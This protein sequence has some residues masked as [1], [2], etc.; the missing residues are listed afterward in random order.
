MITAV[1]FDL[2]DTLYDEIDYVKSG[3]AAVA[4][5]LAGRLGGPSPED[6]YLALWAQF[7]AGNREKTFNAALES[8]GATYD[9]QL[10]RELVQHYRTHSPDIVLPAESRQVLDELG[11]KYTLALLSDGFLPAQKLKVRA[12]AIERYF[13]TILYTEELGREF[14][15]PSPA[16]FERILTTLNTTP[17]QAVYVAD[18][19]LKDFIA[20][21][22]L[23]M[24]TI[25]LIRPNRIHTQTCDH[26][27]ARAQHTLSRL[28][29]LPGLLETL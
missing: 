26:P 8:L 19:Q 21:N 4:A 24:A 13:Q 2:D 10:I 29:D 11:K 18:N 1:I 23:G 27:N 17:Q 9:E 5:H 16:G 12:L 15:K 14:W 6:I 28:V 20:P 22:Q 25:Q 3:L 7:K